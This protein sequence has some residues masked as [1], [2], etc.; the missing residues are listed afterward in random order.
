MQRK[1]YLLMPLK[2]TARNTLGSTLSSREH[3]ST[4]NIPYAQAKR[5]GFAMII[6]VVVMIV[7]SVIM[8]FTLNQTTQ[9]AKR[10]ADM[11]LYEQ[12]EL[13]TKSAIEYALFKIAEGGCQ[14][15]LNFTLDNIYNINISMRYVYTQAATNVAGTACNE[16]MYPYITTNEQNGSVLMD[17]SVSVDSSDTGSEPIRYFRRTIQKL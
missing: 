11:Y 5:R 17:V 13:H 10:T 15:S 6:A 12:A 7:V 4:K 1:N 9:T 3:F 16:Y 14:N 2:S 8:M